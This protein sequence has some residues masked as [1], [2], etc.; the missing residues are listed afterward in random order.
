MFAR[1]TSSITRPMSSG[2]RTGVKRPPVRSAISTGAIGPGERLGA[3]RERMHLHAGAV[4]AV[5]G[6]HRG[7]HVRAEGRLDGERREAVGQEEDDPRR[8][9]VGLR[10]AAAQAE[11]L[12]H[13]LVEARRHVR[14]AVGAA[15][16][17]AR[18]ARAR[19]GRSRS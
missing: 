9:R 4:R 16:E 15:R 7:L 12:D 10:E 5:G 11:E 8:V 3:E 14:A 2:R 19:R 1:F 6:A 17:H 18:R 13:R